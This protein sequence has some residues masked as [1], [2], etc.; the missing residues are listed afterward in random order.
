MPGPGSR[1]PRGVKPN[2]ENPGKLFKRLMAYVFKDYKVHCILVF[3]M[4]VI[5]VLCNV[6]GTLFTRLLIDDY[7]TPLLLEDVP[8]FSPLTHAIIVVARFYVLGIIC[9]YVQARIMVTVTQG[10]M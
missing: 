6:Q 10:V 4:I 9:N 7:I 3:L 8:D 5:G 1:V 2:V